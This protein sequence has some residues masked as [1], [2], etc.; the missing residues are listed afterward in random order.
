[1]NKYVLAFVCAVAA[2]AGG[3]ATHLYYMAEIADMQREQAEAVQK[4]Q[5]DHAAKLAAATDTILLAQTEYD[6]VR[7]ERDR[8]LAR[9]RDNNARRSDKGDSV[10]TLRA[11]VARC[12][13][14]VS[15]LAEAGSR[16]GDGWQRC[17]TKHDALAEVVK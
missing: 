4:E 1:M 15:R 7:A 16:C 6:S 14:M 3:Y 17:A 12:E 5:T 8:L 11:R 2:L 10:E 13:R 9:L